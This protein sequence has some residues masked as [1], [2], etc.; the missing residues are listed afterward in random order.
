[1]QE[2]K[3]HHHHQHKQHQA[4]ATVFKPCSGSAVSVAHDYEPG[5]KKELRR[6]RQEAKSH[7]VSTAPSNEPQQHVLTKSCL[8]AFTVWDKKGERTRIRREGERAIKREN[9]GAGRGGASHPRHS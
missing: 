3:Q 4:E 7:A 5:A 9:R 2:Q 6:A 8:G 1:M